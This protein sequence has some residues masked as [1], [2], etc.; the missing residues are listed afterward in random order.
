MA[1]EEIPDPLVDF[2]GYQTS[3]F[4]SLVSATA[5]VN[6]IPVGDVG[7]FRSL[8]RSFAK[9]LDQATASTLYLGNSLLEQCTLNAGIEAS[10]SF[11]D[12]DD[13]VRGYGSVIDVCDSLLDKAVN[14]DL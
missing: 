8:D 12:V 9:E 13:V 14:I 6:S 10:T 7:Y 2:K 4:K 11:E 1:V 3:L 5:A